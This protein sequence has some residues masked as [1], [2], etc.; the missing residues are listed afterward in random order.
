MNNP[1]THEAAVVIV[2]EVLAGVLGIDADEIDADAAIVDDLGA[3]SLDFVEFNA[4]LEKK[5]SLSLPKM[6]PLAQAGKITGDAEKFNSNKTGLTEA[7][8]ALMNNCLSEYKNITVG[9][10]GLEI[11]SKTSVNNI[12]SLCSNLLNYLPE[13]CPEC[14]HAEAKFSAAG[15][16]VCGSCSVALRPLPGDEADNLHITKYLASVNLTTA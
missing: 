3:D 9:M 8:V 5:F 10:S 2:T 16:I 13:V 11:F 15:K 7:G 6:G 12:A 4:N 14:G 1:C